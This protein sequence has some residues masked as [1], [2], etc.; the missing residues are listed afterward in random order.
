MTRR[1]ELTFL[2]PGA[3]AEEAAAVVAGLAQFLRDHA[4]VPTPPPPRSPWLDASLREGV[5]RAP[6]L[7]A[8]WL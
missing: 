3:S 6:G 4:A 5:A 8:P 7:P 2:G 1:P